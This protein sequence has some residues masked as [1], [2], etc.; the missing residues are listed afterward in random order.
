MNAAEQAGR[1]AHHERTL[2]ELTA[3]SQELDHALERFAAVQPAARELAEYYYG[4]Q[5]RADLESDERGALPPDLPRGVLSEDGA[6]NALEENRRL[7]HQMRE[8]SAGFLNE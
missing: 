2:R 8:L 7:L 5:W 1:I 3:A 6:Y 4:P